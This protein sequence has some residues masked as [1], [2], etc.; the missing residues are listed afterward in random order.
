M[1]GLQKV[2]KMEKKIDELVW[3]S[4]V[5]KTIESVDYSACN[6]KLI[7]FTDGSKLQ[8]DTEAVGF[9]IVGI[10]PRLIGPK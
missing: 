10:V 1:F 7:T 4:M 5:G 6:M 8:L 9:G 3:D 2:G